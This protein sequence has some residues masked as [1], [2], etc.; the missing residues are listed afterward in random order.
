ME[1][2]IPW[3]LI[4]GTLMAFFFALWMISSF[5]RGRPIGFKPYITPIVE[6]VVN[7]INKNPELWN[8]DTNSNV[9]KRRK[10]VD[11][12]IDTLV[13]IVEGNDY[14]KITGILGDSTELVVKNAEYDYVKEVLKNIKRKRAELSIQAGL[15]GG[16]LT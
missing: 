7:D 13:K 2:E 5:I 15:A 8:I 3:G 9:H 16:K 6:R 14:Y 11:D 12:K 1:N 10:S 4:I